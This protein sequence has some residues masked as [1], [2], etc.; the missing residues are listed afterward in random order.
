MTHLVLIMTSMRSLPAIRAE[1]TEELSNNGRN[2]YD[3]N[4]IDITTLQKSIQLPHHPNHWL[5]CSSVKVTSHRRLP[6]PQRRLSS[7]YTDYFNKPNE[8][9]MSAANIG[10][11][12]QV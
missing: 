7:D 9:E 4:T 6:P 8:A 11:Q 5:T 12:E 2:L 1:T 10:L 3:N